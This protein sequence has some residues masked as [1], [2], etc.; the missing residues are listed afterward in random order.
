MDTRILACEF[1]VAH[2]CCLDDLHPLS[3][4]SRE[5]GVMNRECQPFLWTQEV[6][7]PTLGFEVDL[8]VPVRWPGGIYSS[9]VRL[10]DYFDDEK[11][12]WTKNS[13]ISKSLGDRLVDVPK[14][15][16]M[17]MKF[18]RMDVPYLSL[19]VTPDN[20]RSTRPKRYLQP[21]VL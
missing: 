4:H 13:C 2:L 14:A 12:K 19:L 21:R 3:K 1:D 15:D 10:A 20:H 8:G 16:R 7:L 5:R 9:I 11:I 6:V 18:L 17:L